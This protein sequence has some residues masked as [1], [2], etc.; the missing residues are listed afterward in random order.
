[1]SYVCSCIVKYY[2]FS[3]KV[4]VSVGIMGHVGISYVKDI[5]LVK[6]SS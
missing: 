6:L 2:A 5:K 1:M 3:T 4:R